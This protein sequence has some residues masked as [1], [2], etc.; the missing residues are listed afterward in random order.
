MSAVSQKSKK[1]KLN[2][3]YGIPSESVM[4]SKD[5]QHEAIVKDGAPD[6]KCWVQKRAEAARHDAPSAKN[7]KPV[8]PIGQYLIFMNEKKHRM[9]AYVRCIEH[10][11]AV[12]L[13]RRS[14]ALEMMHLC[15]RCVALLPCESI[16][17]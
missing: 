12:M 7:D 1:K 4:K 11:D 16:F 10:G 17:T 3:Y 5:K 2:A 14:L 15:E 6:G 9:E 13:S 8:Y